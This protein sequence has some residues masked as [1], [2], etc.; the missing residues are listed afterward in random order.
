MAELPI[1]PGIK[2]GWRSD[3]EDR[4]SLRASCADRNAVAMLA[5]QYSDDNEELSARIR[6]V[7]RVHNQ[8]SQ[9]SCR[10]HSGS[11]AAE[12]CLLIA[13][14]EISTQLSPQFF[15]IET[16]KIDGIRGDA[17]STI[18][19]G[20]KLLETV[21]CCEDA[22]WPYPQPVKYQTRPPQTTIA[23][24]RQNAAAFKTRKHYDLPDYDSA[25]TFL[26]SGQGPIDIGI[27]W[28]KSMNSAVVSEYSGP[29][30]GSHAVLLSCLSRRKDRS[31]RPFIWLLNSWGANWGNDGWSEIS[32]ATYDGFRRARGNVMVG[33]SDMESPTPRPLDFLR[34]PV[35]H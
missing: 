17:G 29:A 21:G 20:I 14:G 2:W 9:G 4:D 22:L 1:P 32:P 23:A 16:Q 28:R 6:D 27:A 18:Y 33:V 31:G 7:M 13:S 8:G 12:V 24:C 11:S 34:N 35:T 26:A 10:G 25:R 15:Y 30:G 5:G 19:G 3:V